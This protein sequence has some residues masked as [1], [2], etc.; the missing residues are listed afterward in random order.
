MLTVII[1][2]ISILQLPDNQIDPG[3]CIMRQVPPLIS[4]CQSRKS[5]RNTHIFAQNEEKGRDVAHAHSQVPR[6]RLMLHVAGESVASCP[7]GAARTRL[8]LGVISPL[9][10]GA[11]NDCGGGGH[12][13]RAVLSD[14][15]G[16]P[17]GD[18][19]V[20]ANVATLNS[21]PLNCGRLGV[22]TGHDTDC[23]LGR[24]LIIR[25]VEGHGR[26][27]IS[28]KAFFGLLENRLEWRLTHW[29]HQRMTL[30][31]TPSQLSAV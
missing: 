15:I 16:N 21:P 9:L 12:A 8:A 10:V 3:T 11:A 19:S 24:I 4:D 20:G 1:K 18:A 31:P 6:A 14:K 5:A 25:T 29:A 23:D 17:L 26:D 7:K 22:L 30:P 28:T 2:Y 27:R 13:V